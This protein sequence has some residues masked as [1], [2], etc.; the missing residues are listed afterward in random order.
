M[1]SIT[2][3]DELDTFQKVEEFARVAIADK[4]IFK[5][6]I[7]NDTDLLFSKLF[8]LSDESTLLSLLALAGRME[9]TF[10]Q[11]L[12]KTENLVNDI[13]VLEDLDSLKSTDDRYY[14]VKL[15][16]RLR[17]SWLYPWALKRL[18]AEV[19]G[20]KLRVSYLN[21]VLSEQI[22]LSQ[23][24]SDIG[25]AG[26]TYAKVHKLN[27]SQITIRCIK[28][29]KALISGFSS[30]SLEIEL[31][32]GLAVDS[33]IRKPFSSLKKSQI[34]VNTR[35]KLISHVASLLLV[36]I[37]GRF[38]LAMEANLYTILGK[39]RTWCD[40]N[41]WR[42]LVLD[43]APLKKLSDI[44]GEAISVAVRRGTTDDE[45]LNYYQNS[46]ATKHHFIDNCQ[47]IAL[48]ENITKDAAD[49]LKSE[50]KKKQ[51]RKIIRSDSEVKSAIQSNQL[52]DLLINLEY[53]LAK[54]KLL[55]AAVSDIEVFDPS[56][57]PVLKST[58]SQWS[59]IKEI[60]HRLAELQ[61]LKLVGEVD[62][63]EAVDLKLFEMAESMVGECHYG[64]VTRPA[65]VKFEDNSNKVIMKGILKGIKV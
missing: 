26:N 6:D 43:N 29:V 55:D 62:K 53:G 23:I 18:W 51:N 34:K 5:W 10:D 59:V 30:R 63:V 45:L 19:S 40:D 38:S 42:N 22:S 47:R 24:L 13:P 16:S 32:I 28:V 61:S 17:P 52:A 14:V 8:E 57:V 15:I 27:E 31:T 56:L 35:N 48:L 37:E 60:T 20:E 50:G 54:M 41:S 1:F 3:L 49:W 9:E 4:S 11:F 58:V 25:D 46:V 44:I 21:I 33:L 65:I 64:T 2:D 7:P 36:L 12:F 39:M